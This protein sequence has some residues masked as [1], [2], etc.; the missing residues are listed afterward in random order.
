MLDVRLEPDGRSLD[1]H[2]PLHV[3]INSVLQGFARNFRTC[4]CPDPAVRIHLSDAWR[5]GGLRIRRIEACC[6]SMR[7]E[8]ILTMPGVAPSVRRQVRSRR[9]EV[10]N[11]KP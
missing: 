11:V 2:L 3:A 4:G 5:S 9:H 1:L 10:A 6:D 7:D 8:A